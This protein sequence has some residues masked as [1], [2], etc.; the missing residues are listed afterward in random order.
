MALK[1]VSGN[2]VTPARTRIGLP[3]PPQATGTVLATRQSVAAWNGSNPSP[4]KTS[5]A[6]ATGPPP[7]PVTFRNAP[8]AERDQR[9]GPGRL[10]DDSTAMDSFITRN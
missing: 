6:M 1:A 3:T 2:P 8:E 9:D 4:I 5:P 10:S 7:P